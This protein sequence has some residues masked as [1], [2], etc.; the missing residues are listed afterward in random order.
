MKKDF[1]LRFRQFE[2]E[3]WYRWGGH[4]SPRT[5]KP[6][7]REGGRE[8]LQVPAASGVQARQ[9]CWGHLEAFVFPPSFLG[10]SAQH[11]CLC[12]LLGAASGRRRLL[13]ADCEV[14]VLLALDCRD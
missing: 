8:T 14:R 6:G 13:P 3:T 7:E 1:E 10:A 4:G 5:R 12:G 2:F 9:R 11:P